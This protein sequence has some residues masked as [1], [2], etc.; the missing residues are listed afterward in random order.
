MPRRGYPVVI[1]RGTLVEALSI[2]I[3]KFS[4]KGILGLITICAMIWGVYKD[5]LNAKLHKELNEGYKDLYK[6]HR[7]LTQ[8]LAK[9]IDTNYVETVNHDKEQAKLSRS[10][11]GSFKQLERGQGEDK[12][13]KASEDPKAP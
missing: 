9:L 6:E 7:G 8:D 1:K 13:L 3:E 5:F 12:L 10:N 11:T 4:E 2:L